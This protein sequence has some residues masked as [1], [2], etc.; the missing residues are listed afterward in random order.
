LEKE[1]GL[2]ESEWWGD[3]QNRKMFTLTERGKA[4]YWALEN[5][6]ESTFLDEWQQE[7]DSRERAALKA[8]TEPHQIDY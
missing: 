1:H 4:V 3:S 7:E 5:L 8:L 6:L 2:V